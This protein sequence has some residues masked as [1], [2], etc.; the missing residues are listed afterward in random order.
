M[1][2]RVLCLHNKYLYNTNMDRTFFHGYDAIDNHSEV[3]DFVYSGRG[4]DNYNTDLTVDQ[5]INIIYKDK[6]KPNVVLGF[7]YYRYKGFRDLKILK[8]SRADET[9]KEVQTVKTLQD[10]K[11][12]L[13]IFHHKNGMLSLQKRP[14]VKGIRFE[15][16]PRIV[17]INLFKDYQEKRVYDILLVG[18]LDRKIYPFRCRLADIIERDWF[19][20]YRCKI[21]KHPGYSVSLGQD[22]DIVMRAYAKEVNRA[23]LVVSC[24][25]IYRYA[26]SKFLEVPASFSVLA[27]DLPDERREFYSKFVLELSHKDRDKE[28]ENKI[29]NFISNREQYRNYLMN[30]YN[31]VRD[32]MNPIKYADKFVRVV[33]DM[34]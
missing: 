6:K 24:S 22:K 30:G 18:R 2:L 15:N 14:E 34:L 19:K 16:I 1:N 20:K 10:N 23:R 27:S 8:V 26:L 3:E 4:W 33:Q 32:N 29:V 21:L 17:N 5:N 31:L 7:Q 11:M 28:L 12:D 25:S 13:V 9:Y